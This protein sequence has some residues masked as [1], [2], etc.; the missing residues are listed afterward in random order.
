MKHVIDRKTGIP[1]DSSAAGRLIICPTP[2]G[3]LEDVTL[4]VIRALSEADLV[5]CED[6]RHT[7]KLLARHGIKA[8]LV[9][10]YEHNERRRTQE[11]VERI[12]QGQVVA[13]V[14]DA[15]MPTISDPGTAV[16]DACIDA[17][18]TV[19]PLPGASAAITALAASGMAREPWRFVGFLPKTEPALVKLLEE[20]RGSLTVAF[21]SP[22]RIARTLARLAKI[23]PGMEVALC[24]ELT[25]VHEEILR[26]SALQLAERFDG[27]EPRGEFVLVIAPTGDGSGLK[28]GQLV[29]EIDQLVRA[30][31]KPRTAATVVA[32]LGGGS[33]VRP[34]QLYKAYLEQNS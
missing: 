21:E 4:R 29:E 20:G 5:A 8:N 2:I 1:S 15:G 3:N 28:A 33:R 18:L 25:K 23:D 31:A 13:L 32:R 19:E 10:Y 27:I 34:N 26:G 17:G 6:T 9:S 22:N 11:L 12:E 24:R 16:V 7:R 14:T 30:G